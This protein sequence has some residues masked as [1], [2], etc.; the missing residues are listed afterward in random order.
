MIGIR[1]LVNKKLS[2]I[3]TPNFNLKEIPTEIEIPKV[4]ILGP[5][6]SFA[7]KYVVVGTFSW[8]KD[9]YKS[10]TTSVRLLD[11]SIK[12]YSQHNTTHIKSH[13]FNRR[14]I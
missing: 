3:F 13:K 4:S 8:L 9:T 10:P 6:P 7:K 2:Y 5:S 1:D 14:Q 11:V 12:R